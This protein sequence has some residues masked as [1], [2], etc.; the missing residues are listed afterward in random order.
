MQIPVGHY[1]AASACINANFAQI[2]STYVF[3]SRSSGGGT[4]SMDTT[5]SVTVRSVVFNDVS[6]TEAEFTNVTAGVTSVGSRFLC[7]TA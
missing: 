2:G 5:T 6:V 1:N 4:P 7:R 3:T